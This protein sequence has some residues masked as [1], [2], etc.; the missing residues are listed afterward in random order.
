MRRPNTRA[1]LRSRQSMRSSTA[2]QHR[3]L[4]PAPASAHLPEQTTEFNL[5][6]KQKSL[7]DVSGISLFA[8]SMGGVGFIKPPDI[9]GMCRGKY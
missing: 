6:T 4:A 8:Y 5:F 3:S 1:S 9:T 7:P 2:S